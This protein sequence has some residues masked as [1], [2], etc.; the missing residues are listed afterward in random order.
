MKLKTILP[1]LFTCVLAIGLL[2]APLLAKDKKSK[3]EAKAKISK[4]EAGKIALAKVPHGK[5]KEAELEEENGKLVWSFDIAT[6]HSKDIT[7]V[8]VNAI[9][10]EVVSLEKETP[11]DQKKEK[12]KEA[13]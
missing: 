7:E 8:Q 1:C 12:K 3:L 10:G 11:A 13:K 6:P 5:I 9:T 2:D 4:K